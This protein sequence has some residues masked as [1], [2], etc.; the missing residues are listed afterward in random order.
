MHRFRIPQLVVGAGAAVLL[1]V[2]AVGFL[3]RASSG[4]DVDAGGS[5]GSVAIAGF[6]FDPEATSVEIGTRVTWTNADDFTHNVTS[7]G[8]GPLDS[9]DI[10]AGATYGATFDAPGTYVYS[11]TLHPDMTGTIEVTG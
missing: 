3:G 6:R 8:D 1:A 11:C 7:D 2:S 10:A 5:P 4:G 9:G